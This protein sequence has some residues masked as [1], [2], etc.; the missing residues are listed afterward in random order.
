MRD[1]KRIMRRTDIEEIRSFLLD[2]IELTNRCEKTDAES[3][4]KRLKDGEAALWEFLE[5][6][7]PDGEERDAAYGLICGAI[8]TN[9][10]V[11][12]EL[13]IRLGVNMIFGLIQSAPLKELSD[14]E[15]GKERWADNPLP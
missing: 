12:T 1:F 7:Y 13:G 14:E 15:N 8:V 5:N 11:Y 9:Q 2:G 3:Y 6:L 4:E 10:E